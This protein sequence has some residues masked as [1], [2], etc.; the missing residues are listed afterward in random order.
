MKNNYILADD[1]EHIKQQLESFEGYEFSKD[2][3][4]R[5]AARGL[6]LSELAKRV[7]VSHTMVSKWLN[8]GARPH[9]KERFKELGM[10]LGMNVEELNDFLCRNCYPRLY[11]KNPLDIVCRFILDAFSG[12]GDIIEK[13]RDMIKSYKLDDYILTDEPEEIKTNYL[14][15]DFARV[16]SVASF[17]KWLLEHDNYFKAYD[18]NYIPHTELI[19]FILFHIGEQSINDMYVAGEM[20]VAVRNLLYP[21]IADREITVKGLRAKLIVFGL[22]K[23]MTEDE[24]DIMLEL[25]GFGL[26]SEPVTRIDHALLTSLR[27]AHERYPYFEY[28]NVADILG[29]LDVQDGLYA[30]YQ[31]KER[32]ASDCVRYYEA[33]G[34]KS[35]VERLFEETYSSYNDSGI[36]QYVIDV[37]ELLNKAG[38]LSEQETG[39]YI[40]LTQI[41]RSKGRS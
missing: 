30:F 32:R 28:H 29:G 35:E 36:L 18:K 21:L 37:F 24:I 9:G 34:R 38:V 12:S 25:A 33:E 11:V 4:G 8:K 17:E 22:Y 31:E 10:A 7:Y 41:Y 20:P 26:L 1:I 16:K 19:R 23:N 2:I 14:S 40:P 15:L 39:E 5:M 6:T 27:C 3:A 13:Y